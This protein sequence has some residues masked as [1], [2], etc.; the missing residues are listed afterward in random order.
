MPSTSGVRHAIAWFL[1][2]GYGTVVV[3]VAFWPSPVDR[4]VAGL[5]A[6]VLD[7]L[8]ER[9]VPAFVDYTFVEFTANVAFFVPVGIAIGLAL[10]LRAFFVMFLLGPAVSIAV[11]L[12]QG[13]FLEAR[14]ATVH[15]V[16][17]NAIGATLGVAIALALRALVAMRDERVIAQ[18]EARRAGRVS[19]EE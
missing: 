15:D 5:L 11:E 1:A 17:A 6:R 10:P 14:Y 12:I 4:P 3:F 2:L 19:G 8:H 18:W 7:E 9:G 16:V 13:A